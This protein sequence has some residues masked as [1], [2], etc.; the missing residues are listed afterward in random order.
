MQPV[1]NIALILILGLELMIIGLDNN[2]IKI[3]FIGNI[4]TLIGWILNIIAIVI[5]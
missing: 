1:N 4:L 2:N 5:K 3:K